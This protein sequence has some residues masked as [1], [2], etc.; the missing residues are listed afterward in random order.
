MGCTAAAL[1]IDEEGEVVCA[2]AGEQVANSSE[3]AKLEKLKS[4]AALKCYYE[5]EL[6]I[7]QEQLKVQ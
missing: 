1:A 7:A 4:E 2:S 3:T 5:A 6:Q